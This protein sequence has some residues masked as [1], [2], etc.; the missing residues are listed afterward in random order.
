MK[1]LNCDNVDQVMGLFANN[2]MSYNALRSK[3]SDGEPSLSEMT[4]AAIKILDNKKNV[5]GFVLMVE[6][7]KIDEAHHQNL[8]KMALEEFVEFERAIEEAVNMSNEDTLIIVTSDHGHGMLFN[9]HAPRGNDILGNCYH[10][11][12]L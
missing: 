11:V 1:N 12:S 9:G 7:G 10:L 3:F 2:H 4:K 8:A 5:E 6:G